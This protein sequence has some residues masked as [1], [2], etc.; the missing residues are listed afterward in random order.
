MLYGHENTNGIYS[1]YVTDYTHNPDMVPIDRDWC[2]PSLSDKVL[3]LEL[4][5][6]AALKGP[7]MKAGE[8]YFIGNCRMK[9]STGG[10]LEATFSQVNKMRKLDEDAL[11]D[12]PRLVDLLKYVRKLRMCDPTHGRQAK[13]GMASQG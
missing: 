9:R 10:Y 13:G 2:P 3:K 6:E 1:L 12:E 11:E 5:Q 8:Y 4:F 7:E